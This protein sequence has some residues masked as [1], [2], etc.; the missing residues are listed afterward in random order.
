MITGQPA[1]ARPTSPPAPP[2]TH[3]FRLG[4]ERQ[5]R[6]VLDANVF[7]RREYLL[8]LV[9]SALHQDLVVFWSTA[10]LREVS[11][12]VCW[13]AA[14]KASTA[15]APDQPLLSC[16][17]R[18]AIDRAAARLEARVREVE[19]V[20]RYAVPGE[21]VSDEILAAVPDRADWVLIQTALE[22]DAAVLLT[23]DQRH[24]PHGA[25]IAGVRC[26]HP[27]TFLTEFYQQNPGAFRRTSRFVSEAGATLRT[28]LL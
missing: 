5:I 1:V 10:T 18:A 12:V 22:N 3:D 9:G 15:N 20:F 25:V 6:V 16:S 28:S 8:P 24:L 13:T 21:N 4:D 17:L 7:F 19:P 14:L 26:W 27:D 11:K 23:L 2:R